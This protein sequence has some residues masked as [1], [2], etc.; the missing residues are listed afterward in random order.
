MTA[1]TSDMM[2]VVLTLEETLGLVVLRE[3]ILLFSKV[4]Q[5]H[6]YD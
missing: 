6:V 3:S 1:F 4:F 5:T 2:T